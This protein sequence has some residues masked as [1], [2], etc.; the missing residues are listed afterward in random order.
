MI[1]VLENRL[2]GTYLNTIKSRYE[3]PMPNIMLNEEKLDALFPKS[4]IRH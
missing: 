4:G 2:E 3:K 1:K